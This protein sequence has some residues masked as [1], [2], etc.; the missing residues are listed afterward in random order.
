M[1]SYVSKHLLFTS[2]GPTSNDLVQCDIKGRP[3]IDKVRAGRTKTS[4]TG[5]W[6]VAFKLVLVLLFL[7][8]FSVVQGCVKSCRSMFL[9][10]VTVLD[11]SVEML[12]CL[13]GELQALQALR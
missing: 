13:N 10:I 3:I 12:I 6:R 4:S 2:D 1:A 8:G 9:N 7:A 5:R 11:G